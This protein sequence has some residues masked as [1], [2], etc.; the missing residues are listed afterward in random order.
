M[1]I[2]IFGSVEVLCSDCFSNCELLTSVM[3]QSKSHLS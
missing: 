3:F 1:M 2:E